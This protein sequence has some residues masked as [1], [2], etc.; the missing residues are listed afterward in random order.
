MKEI[1]LKVPGKEDVE[2]VLKYKKEFENSG[3]EFVDW[4]GIGN[5]GKWLKEIQGE[6]V[7]KSDTGYE[8]VKMFLLYRKTD[9][10]LVGVAECRVVL[11]DFLFQYFDHIGY[12]IR[13]S[14]QKKGYGTK[15]LELL[16]VECKKFKMDK[17]VIVCFKENKASA[18]IIKNNGGVLENEILDE[19]GKEILQ[20]YI[21]NLL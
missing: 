19:N 4:E 12:S 7:E 3:Q 15:I 17:V 5:L 1:Y 11:S 16:L 18:K 2:N 8:H 6:V 14:E 21:V 20:R 13:P 10:L 9:G